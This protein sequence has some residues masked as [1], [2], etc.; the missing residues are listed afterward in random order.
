MARRTNIR[1][2]FDTYRWEL[3][4]IVGIP[5]ITGIWRGVVG[6]L[7]VVLLGDGSAPFE[8]NM[9]VGSVVGLLLLAVSYLR[10]RNLGRDLLALLWGYVIAASVIGAT[11]HGV[12]FLVGVIFPT[13]D[14]L[15]IPLRTLSIGGLASLLGILALL[16]F[17]RRASRLSLMH[18][19]F[20]LV[21]SSL[22]VIGSV[23]GSRVSGVNSYPLL[24]NFL[25]G[26]AIGVTVA[27]AKVW[28]LGNFDRRGTRFHRDAVIGLLATVI[29]SGYARV[30]IADL[31][32]YAEGP[33]LAILPWLDV[34][35]GLAAFAVTTV[36]ELAMLLVFFALVYLVRVRPPTA[37][38]EPEPETPT[39]APGE[40]R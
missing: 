9:F 30:L 7:L 13:E 32:G 26:G 14:R 39:A 19:A 25:A 2:F 35:F 38:A 21:F 20:L 11:A 4:L 3:W 34:V 1:S 31:I 23:T 40:E 36:Y 33:Y 24:V 15:A 10:V 29:L 8:L 17:A 6:P 5:V 22:S 28:L 37:D 12:L 27:L 16:W 18:A